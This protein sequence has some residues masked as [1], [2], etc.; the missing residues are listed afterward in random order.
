MQRK[1]LLIGSIVLVGTLCAAV[2]VCAAADAQPAAKPAMKNAKAASSDVKRGEYL[3]NFGGCND[4]HTPKTM[5]PKGPEPDMTRALSGHPSAT[6]VPP[7]PADALGPGKWMAV[8]NGDLSAWGGPWGVSFAANLT[9]DKR[10]GLGDWTVD[11]FIRTMRT[12]K[13]LGVGRDILPPMPWFSLAVLT[14]ADLR[15]IFA[16]LRSIKPIEN[17]V[18]AP[19]PPK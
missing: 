6:Q 13:H 1:S 14:D 16:Y 2:D 4:C 15:A 7:V 18:P 12:G 11:Q 17:Q 8:T 19:I 3:V 10:T 9:P 5:T